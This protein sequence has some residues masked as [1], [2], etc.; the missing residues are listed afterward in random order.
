M[1][2]S[3]EVIHCRWFGC[4]AIPFWRKGSSTKARGKLSY[5]DR[6]KETRKTVGSRQAVKDL[7][8]VMYNDGVY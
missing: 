6:Q 8:K 2:F 5:G 4:D 3:A 1:A 7:A